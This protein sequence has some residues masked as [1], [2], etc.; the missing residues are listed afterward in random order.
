MQ[1]LKTKI[2]HTIYIPDYLRKWK[3]DNSTKDLATS[4]LFEILD[5]YFKGV[6]GNY[7]SNRN[8][9]ILCNKIDDLS[10]E[11]SQITDPDIYLQN[12]LFIGQTIELW[13]DLAISL[14]EFEVATNLRKLLNNEYA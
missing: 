12:W 7:L 11:F 14:E 2:S 3:C 6:T 1:E 13:T 10:Y 8:V 9:K 5:C 4:I